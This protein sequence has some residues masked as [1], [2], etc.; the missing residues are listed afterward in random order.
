MAKV[1]IPGRLT[2]GTVALRSIDPRQPPTIDFE[3]LKGDEGIHDIQAL[4]E[5]VD[6]FMPG[7]EGAP[8]RYHPF[9]LHQPAE[10]DDISQNL[11]DEAFGHYPTSTC[12]MGPFEDKNACVIRSFVL[13]ALSVCAL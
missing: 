7:F 3:W 6:L 9:T 10:D 4:T 11:R 12:R 13:T 2:D 8:G 5:G 1:H